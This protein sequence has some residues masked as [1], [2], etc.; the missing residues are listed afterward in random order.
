MHH[1]V[2]PA[3]PPLVHGAT[4]EPVATGLR[5]TVHPA[6][7][8]PLRAAMLVGVLAVASALAFE[9]SD[10]AALGIVAFFLLALS[11]RSW[12]LPRHYT[13]DNDG[14]G[15]AGPL[16]ATH[17]LPWSNVRRVTRGR[18]GIY[19]STLHSRSRFVRDRGLFLR[20]AG[21][22]PTVS[23]PSRTVGRDVVLRFVEGSVKPS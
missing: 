17:H 23:L 9:Y 18:F 6:A 21:M 8:D 7:D 15:E 16:C 1:V 3:V 14:A 10:S 19:L 20:T 12:F 13:L 11:L 4:T 22:R 5:W 2:T